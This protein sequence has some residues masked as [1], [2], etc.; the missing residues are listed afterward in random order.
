M[1]NHPLAITDEGSLH[2][3]RTEIPNTV[4]RGLKSRPLSV[5]AKW[6]Y[7]YLKSVAGDTGE[8]RQGTTALAQGSGISRAQ[9]SRARH[10][11]VAAQLVHIAPGRRP[12]RDTTH[13][14]IND[15]WLQNMQEF[16]SSFGVSTRD[17]NSDEIVDT[18]QEKYGHYVSTRDS[19]N[20]ASVS[21]RD[22]SVSTRAQKKIYLKKEEI[23]SPGFLAY[24]AAHPIKQGKARAWTLWQ[25]QQLEPLT[26]QIVQSVRDH[27]TYDPKWPMFAP[28]LDTYLHNKRWE[29]E[30]D[31]PHSGT[32]RKVV[33]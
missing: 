10:E 24:H 16:A 25:K 19:E 12:Y 7:V 32:P 2:K 22:S 33:L 31:M 8:C 6:L 9:V 18:R 29:D 27:L 26:N 11:L 4:V 14:R 1:A 15:I 30:L 17:T 28:H 23:Y 20:G 5:Y 21:T 3:Y 13:I